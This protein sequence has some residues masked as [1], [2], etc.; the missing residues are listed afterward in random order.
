MRGSLFPPKRPWVI[1][2]ESGGHVKPV[3]KLELASRGCRRPRQPPIEHRSPATIRRPRPIFTG[4]RSTPDATSAGS[5]VDR[6]G[7][8]N[9]P[10]KSWPIGVSHGLDCLREQLTAFTTTFFNGGELLCSLSRVTS[11]LPEA[12][13]SLPFAPA[14]VRVRPTGPD[15]TAV[16][17]PHANQAAGPRASRLRPRTPAYRG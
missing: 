12:I 6:R 17:G 5:G 1:L 14:G 16:R 15:R 10:R 4:L 2:P 9:R 8:H 3:G 7:P 13:T 11:R